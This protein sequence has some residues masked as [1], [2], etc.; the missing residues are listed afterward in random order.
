[1][2]AH[3][4]LYMLHSHINH[5]CSPNV[6]VRHIIPNNIQRIT[7]IARR[8]IEPGEELVASYVDPSGDLWKRRREL[9][10]WGFGICKCQRCL[11]EEKVAPPEDK[12]TVQLEDEVRGFLGI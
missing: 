1:M 2:E 6:S 4:G 10:E 9:K 7:V 8:A 3:G 12:E 11:E 5:S